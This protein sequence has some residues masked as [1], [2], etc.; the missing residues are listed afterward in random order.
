MKRVYKD[1]Q[2]RT[3]IKKK[4]KIWYLPLQLQALLQAKNKQNKNSLQK[5]ENHYKI[6][7]TLWKTNSQVITDG[8][9]SLCQ[10]LLLFFMS[11]NNVVAKIIHPSCRLMKEWQVPFIS[12]QRVFL[13]FT[14]LLCLFP[15]LTQSHS[16]RG[17]LRYGGNIT[18]SLARSP[19]TRSSG[20]G[21]H[22]QTAQ[23][24]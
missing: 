8:C 17:N 10:H 4:V 3:N 21:S 24:L 6:H 12:L 14:P 16:R 18:D 13:S 2:F 19:W 23:C 7:Y 5:K 1:L 9:S 22:R 11:L 20:P 15:S